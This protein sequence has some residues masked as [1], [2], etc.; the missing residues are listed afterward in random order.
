NPDARKSAGR[1]P[2][3]ATVINAQ[4]RAG[5]EIPKVTTLYPGKLPIGEDGTHYS[6]EGYIML[7]KITATAVEEFYKAKK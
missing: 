3:I 4:N 1:R 2:Y 7:G 5:R 6:S